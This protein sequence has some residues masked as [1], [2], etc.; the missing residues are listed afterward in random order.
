M[1]SYK[2]EIRTV[3]NK[4][5]ASIPIIGTYD[6]ATTAFNKACE[7]LQILKGRFLYPTKCKAVKI[8]NGNP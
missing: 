1:N 3:S 7:N 2:L 4:L 5:L 6:N 8:T